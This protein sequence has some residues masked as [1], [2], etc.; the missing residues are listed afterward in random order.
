MIDS[1]QNGSSAQQQKRKVKKEEE[2]KRNHLKLNVQQKEEIAKQ[3]V[4][5]LPGKNSH[6]IIIKKNPKNKQLISSRSPRT[7]A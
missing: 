3:K 6:D 2:K 1:I 4:N 5:P 7:V